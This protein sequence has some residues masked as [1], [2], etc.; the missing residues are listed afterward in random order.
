M[1]SHGLSELVYPSI[2]FYLLYVLGDLIQYLIILDYSNHIRRD[3]SAA[4]VIPLMPFY[5]A[6]QRLIT[7]FAVVEEMLSRRSFRD[8]FVP[9][10][11]QRDMAL[12]AAGKVKEML[13]GVRWLRCTNAHRP[14]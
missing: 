2:L 8:G 5:Q 13:S 12:V 11:S 9:S 7:T 3:L 10:M 6:Y 4:L 1:G 14:W